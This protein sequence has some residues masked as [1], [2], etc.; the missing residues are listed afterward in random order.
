M[1]EV[2]PA[3]AVS[4]FVLA[5]GLGVLLWRRSRAGG[6]ERAA[7]AAERERLERQQADVD[8]AE[9]DLGRRA[10]ELDRRAQEADRLAASLD[11]RGQSLDRRAGELDHQVT[12]LEERER[13]FEK[14]QKTAWAEGR[15]ELER[16]AGLTEEEARDEIKQA[17]EQDARRRA[18]VTRRQVEQEARRQAERTARRI[19]VDAI[20][21][22]AVAPAGQAAVSVL[23]LPSEAVKGR[24]IGREGRN[25]RTFEQLTGADL[26]IDDTPGVVLVSCFDPRR[27]AVAVAAL[28]E[29]VADGRI[30]PSSIEAACERARETVAAEG[31]EAVA[32]ALVAAGVAD[33]APELLGFLAV[34]HHRTSYGQNVLDHLVEAAQ[35]AGGM[36]AE[37]GLDAASCRRAAFLHDIGK[38]V[39]LDQE[40]SHAALGAEMARRAGESAA[41]VNAIAAHHGEVAP[42][43]A[44]AVLTQ[45]ADA[46]SAGRPG[47]RREWAEDYAARLRRLEE[48]ACAHDGIDRAFAVRA[49][50]EVR[51]MV[52]PEAVDDHQT[53]RLASDIACE[54][55]TE[56]VYPGQVT[57]TVI[58]ESRATAVAV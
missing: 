14:V 56:L 36:A 11:E 55:E 44:E 22:V 21:R 43:T 57:V 26:V 39:T 27:R 13:S 37:I 34:L 41:V 12:D 53:A 40:G 25:I 24:L 18:A 54:I 8:A 31:E 35:L 38:A 7:L 6:A 42:E 52:L 46:V 58:R 45:V 9:A 15:A 29:L 30:H 49:G 33:L 2:W 4:A 51:V 28:K 47:A 3:L 1:N 50:R 17:V 16:L 32:Q 23:D 48:I 19:L 20:S 10:L 5:A